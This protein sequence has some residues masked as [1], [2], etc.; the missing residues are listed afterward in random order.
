MLFR[1]SFKFEKWWST[2]PDFENVVIKAWNIEGRYRNNMDRW[3]AKVRGFRKSAKGWSANIDAEIR[4]HKK[5][6][7]EEYDSLDVKAENQI[8]ED[9]DRSRLDNIL[10]ELN[11]YW[12]IEEIKAKQRARD[13]D[14]KEGDRNTAYF[15]AVAN[16]RRRKK[17]ISV[18]DGPDGPET[19]TKGMLKIAVD[20]YKDLFKYE[21]RAEIRIRDDFSK[22]WWQIY[23]VD[24]FE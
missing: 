5:A 16:Q 6:L 7:M 15:H 3:Q 19:E 2:R 18:L 22:F 4:K 8:L 24:L 21:N 23:F 20:F 10:S 13:R 1:S 9:D 17:L 14:I 11:S 12:I